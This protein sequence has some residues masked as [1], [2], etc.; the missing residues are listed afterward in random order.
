MGK[1]VMGWDGVGRDRTGRDGIERDVG[2]DATGG[3]WDRTRRDGMRR[4]AIKWGGMGSIWLG[5]EDAM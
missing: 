3:D 4:D 5:W 2:L 1:N